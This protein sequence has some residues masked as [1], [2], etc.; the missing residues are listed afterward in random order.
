MTEGQVAGH[1]AGNAFGAGAAQRHNP[2]RGLGHCRYETPWQTFQAHM[3]HPSR[4][5]ALKTWWLNDHLS[6][7]KC[8]QTQKPPLASAAFH[9]HAQH[10]HG[11]PAAWCTADG[12]LAKI[13]DTR[14]MA[15]L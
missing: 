14:L 15:H 7:N 12:L 11:A 6:F 10:P 5:P 3:H 8:S 13:L 1:Q 4:P 2:K 9:L